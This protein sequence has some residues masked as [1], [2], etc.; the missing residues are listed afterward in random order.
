MSIHLRTL[1][2]LREA[3]RDQTLITGVK[4]INQRWHERAIYA[5]HVDRCQLRWC[6]SP[7]EQITVFFLPAAPGTREWR[8][9]TRLWPA[10]QDA[11]RVIMTATEKP[12]TWRASKRTRRIAGS[13]SLFTACV[14][15]HHCVMAAIEFLLDDRIYVMHTY[16]ANVRSFEFSTRTVEG[17]IISRENYSGICHDW[18]AV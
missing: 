8:T 4:L 9:V 2:D 10:Q 17:G 7:G 1:Y 16:E 3:D 13:V 11:S 15:T 5:V 14:T 12:W 6:P 18:K